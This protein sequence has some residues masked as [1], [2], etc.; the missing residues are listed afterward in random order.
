RD[1]A[2]VTEVLK[3]IHKIVNEAIRAQEPGE[4][5]AEG[6]TVDLSRIDFERLRDEF[7]KKV[8]HRHSALKDLRDVVEQKLQQMLTYN[9]LRMDYYR[10]YQEIIADYNREKDRVTVEETFARL[11]DLA[12]NL[13]AEQRRAAEEGLNEE[14][15]ALFDLLFRANISK[16]DR[17]KI[18]Q[19]SKSLL[20]ALRDLIKPMPN[21]IQNVQTQA[22]V[23]MF[24][25][26]MLWEK[27]PKPP[28]TEEDAQ[29]LTDRIYDHVWQRSAT[30]DFLKAAM[31]A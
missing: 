27:L 28:F 23:R 25:L 24:V 4:D 22:E 7:A 12:N 20:S 29:L 8:K 14:E 9:S 21:W 31:A 1:T 5:H 19:A 16:V 18:K 6:L 10:K 26:D 17:E 11:V 13:D 3:E 15:L 30:G 2:D